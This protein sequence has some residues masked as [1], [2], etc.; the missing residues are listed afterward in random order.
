MCL[1]VCPVGAITGD[2]K[3]PHVIDPEKCIK[4]GAC[5]TACKLK[6]VA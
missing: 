1:K 2:R 3:Q 5:I 4:C 6:A